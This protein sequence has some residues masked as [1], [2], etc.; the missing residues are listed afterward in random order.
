[1]RPLVSMDISIFFIVV[2]VAAC[3]GMASIGSSIWMLSHQGVAL[4]EKDYKVW[5]C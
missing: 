1:M 4:L 3:I 5:A 2:A